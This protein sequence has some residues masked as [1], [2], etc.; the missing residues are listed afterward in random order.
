LTDKSAEAHPPLISADANSEHDQPMNLIRI[1]EL[2]PSWLI[3]LSV[4]PSI[5]SVK[6]ASSLGNITAI[7]SSRSS[8][9]TAEGVIFNFKAV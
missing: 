6:L 7:N 8:A 1:D 4:I 2:T 5:S 9:K 3:L